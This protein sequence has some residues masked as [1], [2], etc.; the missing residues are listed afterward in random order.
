MG[1]IQH[2]ANKADDLVDLAR[3]RLPRSSRVRRWLSRLARGLALR[4]PR[5]EITRFL[6]AFAAHRPDAFFVQ[7]GSNDGSQQDPLDPVLERYRWRGILVEPVPYVFEQLKRHRGGDPRFA[8]EQAA[9]ADSDGTRPFYYLEKAADPAGLPRWYDA[10]G[11]F[12]REIVAGHANYIPDIEQRIREMPVACLSFDSLC[13]KHGV[14]RVDVLHMDVEGYDWELLQSIDLAAWRPAV[15]IFEHHHL[16]RATL[17]A[18]HR[19]LGA[20]GYEFL[21]ERLD[22][23]AVHRSTLTGALAREFERASDAVYL[24]TLH[25]A[26]GP[27]PEDADRTLRADNAELEDLRRRY[28]GMALERS[29]RWSAASTARN[30]RLR[31]FRGESLYLWHYREGLQRTRQKFEA[32]LQYLQGRD[33][34]RLLERLREDGAFGCWTY[35]F[36]GPLTV[37]RD[38]LDSVN[39]ILFLE[40]RLGVLDRPGLRVLDVG[41]GYGRLAH[42]FVTAAPRLAD[43]CCADAIPESTFLSRYYLGYRRCMPP[44]RVVPLDEVSALAPGSFDLAVNIHSFPECTLGA[45]RWWVAQLRRLRVPDLLIVPNDGEQ[46]LSSEADGTRLPFDRVLQEAGYRQAH[47][48]AVIADPAVRE[49]TGIKDAFVLF[50]LTDAG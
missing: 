31:H 46:L 11:S 10:L 2:L 49:L 5:P 7:I 3:R 18:C 40:R 45:I 20:L 13:R 28:D 24:A 42:R 1:F 26:G 22:T 8:L 39:E 36:Y 12:R 50:R 41:A 33:A 38:L 43:Y 27:A 4:S 17:D 35:D 29:P 34:P 37:S 6:L 48:E 30:A 9:I 23:L 32:Y 25:Q 21:P 19:R 16:D 47:T 44:A 15:L 14:S